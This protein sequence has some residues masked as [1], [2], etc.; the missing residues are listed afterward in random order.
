MKRDEGTLLDI[1][2]HHDRDL[3]T[4][5]HENHALSPQ[6]GERGRVRG[7]YFHGKSRTRC[8]DVYAGSAEGTI[9]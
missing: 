9:P 6:W 8:S 1:A 4:P 2:N 3:V 5:A 7:V